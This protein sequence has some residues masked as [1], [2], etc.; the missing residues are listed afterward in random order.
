M[1][2]KKTLHIT[3]SQSKIYFVEKYLQQNHRRNHLE[4]NVLQ[5]VRSMSENVINVFTCGILCW[6]YTN[7]IL[8]GV[9]A[10]GTEW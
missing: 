5:C 3:V 7:I 9:G 2:N 1:R 10:I 8:G 4:C 6:A